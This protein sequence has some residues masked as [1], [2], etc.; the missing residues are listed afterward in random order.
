MPHN[1]RNQRM[2]SVLWLLHN[3]TL[4]PAPH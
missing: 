2:D 3:S 4:P 1:G